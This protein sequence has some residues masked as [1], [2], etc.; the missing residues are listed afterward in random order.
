MRISFVLFLFYSYF[1]LSLNAQNNKSFEGIIT[2]KKE[3]MNDTVFN[4]FYIKGS[5]I[6]IDYILKTGKLLKYKI[7]DFKNNEYIVVNPSKK[8]YVQSYINKTTTVKNG[9]LIV[10]KT[11]N[12]KFIQQKKCFQWLVKDK[13][14]NT[15]VSYWVS[16]EGYNYYGDLLE[17]LNET[18]KIF[19]YFS[20]I[21]NSN[22]YIP[23]ISVERSW[24]RDERMK[25]T[26]EKI[27]EISIDDSI[28]DIP[29][30]YLP[31]N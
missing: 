15:V 17:I 12:Y 19:S 28:F 4:N 14:N 13:Q 24:L 1:S 18:E 22:G 26:A 10:D 21:P 30:G 2:Y 23:F 7:I 27:I 6:R 5:K 11:G 16:Y 25:M 20:Q 3:T 29:K 31:F 9:S 8:L